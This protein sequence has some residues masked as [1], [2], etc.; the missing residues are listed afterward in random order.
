MNLK[1]IPRKGIFAGL[2]NTLKDST[3]MLLELKSARRESKFSI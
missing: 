1:K 3:I 2:L